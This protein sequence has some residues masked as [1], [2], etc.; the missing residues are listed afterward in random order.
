[1]A[2][3]TT[4]SAMYR[5]RQSAGGHVF[6]RILLL[7]DDICRQIYRHLADLYEQ[8]RKELSLACLDSERAQEEC[9]DDCRELIGMLMKSFDI[10]EF[11]YSASVG[12]CPSRVV[13]QLKGAIE[14]MQTNLANLRNESSEYYI[15][16]NIMNNLLK[17]SMRVQRQ[18]GSKY[19]EIVLCKRSNSS[20]KHLLFENEKTLFLAEALDLHHKTACA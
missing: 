10:R 13:K 15:E 9:R 3:G 2:E 5:T 16:I 20:V 12:A 14:K 18:I 7:P 6:G 1:M 19:R 17:N 11:G 8:D 4:T